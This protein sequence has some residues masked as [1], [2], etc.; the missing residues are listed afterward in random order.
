MSHALRSMLCLA[1][2]SL[3]VAQAQH[4]PAPAT[5]TVPFSYEEPA[6]GTAKL[7]LDY[8]APF[9]PAKATVLVIADGQQFYVRAGAMKDLKEATFGD[10]VNVVGI[11]TRGTTPAFIDAT[12]NSDGK[13]DWLKAWKVFNSGE[14]V[15]D[16][17]TVRKALVGENGQIDLY[18]R[19]GG[20]Y[21]VHQYLSQ[22]SDHVGRAFTQSAVNPYLNAELGISLDTFWSDLGRQSTTLQQQLQSALTAHPEERIG[23]L[24]T[25]QRQHFFVPADKIAASRADLI[26]A[27]AAGNMEVYRT[28][29]KDYEVDDMTAMYASKDIIPQDVRVLELIAPSGAFDHLGDGGLYPLAET[30]A[31]EIKPLLDMLHA[32]KITLPAFDFAALHRCPADVF[33]LAGRYD[34]AVDYRTEIAL[35]AA[36]PH[37]FLFIADDNHV[38]SALTANGASRRIISTF[39]AQGAQSEAF[40]NVVLDSQRYRWVE[41]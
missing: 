10:A 33:M 28:A 20:A 16:I 8:A 39:F 15:R 2:L 18:G 40:A 3:G 38:F 7:A 6:L 24:M 9:N 30:Q 22:H 14:W 31:F 23:I 11:I 32:G 26:H 1:F 36:Y 27:L 34:E 12:L 5:V 41:R 4:S 17:E 25:L 13:P 29:R 37:H 21:L 19:S 35:A